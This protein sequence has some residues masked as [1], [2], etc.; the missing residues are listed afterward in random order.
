MLSGVLPG[1]SSPYQIPTLKPVRPD[2]S[3][4]GTS[5]TTGERSSPVTP[6]ARSLPALTCCS[7]DA[8]LANS[9]NAVE[10]QIWMVLTP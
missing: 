2:S 3:S 9:T 8:M 1:A 10:S 6:S 5:G 7:E 4:V